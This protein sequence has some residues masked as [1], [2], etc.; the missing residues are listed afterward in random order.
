ML[1]VMSHDSGSGM[2]DVV[3][4]SRFVIRDTLAIFR[5]A[6]DLEIGGKK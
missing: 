1:L 6:L 3:Y 4:D 2:R 5:S